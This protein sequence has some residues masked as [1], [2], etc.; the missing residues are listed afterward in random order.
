MRTM[1]MIDSNGELHSH[2]TAV[3]KVLE[4]LAGPYATAS[5]LML[6]PKPLRDLVYNWISENRYKIFGEAD[7]CRLP[8]EDDFA[9]FI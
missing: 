2:S 6:V 8:D 9:R 5:Y 4:Q 7:E 1:Y 3:I